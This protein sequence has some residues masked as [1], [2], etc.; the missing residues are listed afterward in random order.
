M[1]LLRNGE[2]DFALAQ[3]DAVLQYCNYYFDSTLVLIEPLYVEYLHI[4]VRDPFELAGTSGLTQKRIFLGPIK[5]GS[6]ITSKLLLDLMGVSTAQYTRV[7]AAQLEDVRNLL[8][9]DS[10][11]VVM[12]VG[13]LGNEFI[14]ELLD[15]TC[16]RLFPLDR[17]ASRRIILETPHSNLGIL[18][19]RSIP[20]RTYKRG[21]KGEISTIAV[22][23]VLAVSRGGYPEG[24]ID[25]VKS[26]V[27]SAISVVVGTG[28]QGDMSLHEYVPP[29]LGVQISDK[30]WPPRKGLPSFWIN[31]MAAVIII[32]LMLWAIKKYSVGLLRL[33]RGRAMAL[34]CGSVLFIFLFCSVAIYS[35][36]QSV[37]EHFGSLP[38]TVWSIFVYLTSGLGDRV[39]IT[40]GGHV[41]T[42]IILIT[43]P[44]F[45]AVLTGFFASSIILNALERKMA[46]NLKDHYVI[47]NWSNRALRV[48]EQIHSEAQ[49]SGG[50]NVVVVVSDDPE[51]NLKE[52]Q[53]RFTSRS[54]KRA[55]E[56]VYFCPGDPCDEQS[57]L[58]ANV[59]DANCVVIMSDPKE[60]GSADEKTLRSFLTIQRIGENHGVKLNVVVELTNLEN[61]TVVENLARHF[62]GTVDLVAAGRIRTLLLAHSTLIP[63]LTKFYRDL[64][65]FGPDTNELYL[66]EVPASAI[67]MTFAE[68]GAKIFQNNSADPVVPVGLQRVEEGEPKLVTNPR[69][70][71]P[72]GKENPYNRLQEGDRLLVMSYDRP[73]P[74]ELPA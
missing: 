38:E 53:K 45:L 49:Y 67:G 13:T 15:S 26:V 65:Y 25:L 8:R 69:P 1:L 41:I 23:V 58:N 68:Y 10:L 42:S 74:K 60:T 14:R 21:Q 70:L 24:A 63:G 35:L 32:F 33:F 18:G 12:Y 22:P 27:D 34:A 3:L 5:S 47:L 56:D 40:P 36:E 37:N 54:S 2:A 43:G 72:E 51:L 39:P 71:T 55:F 64:L 46:K 31:M 4:V 6:A 9:E 28:V 62:P 30:H 61:A 48:I 44:L 50:P 7:Q 57:L 73:K 29:P 59:E 20:P 66:V 52:L 19:V 16:C 11:D 17:T